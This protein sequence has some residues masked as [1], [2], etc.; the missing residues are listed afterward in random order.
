MGF[1]GSV[2]QLNTERRT[3]G[4]IRETHSGVEGDERQPSL[5]HATLYP[6]KLTASM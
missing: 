3:V 6:K 2:G 5:A 1:S 4:F